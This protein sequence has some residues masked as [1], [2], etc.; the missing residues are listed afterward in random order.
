MTLSKFYNKLRID[1]LKT[2]A[3]DIPEHSI[4][5][6]DKSLKRLLGAT[7]YSYVKLAKRI[8]VANTTIYHY[9]NGMRKPD[10]KIM[11]DI[12]K[13]FD[14]KPS[15]FLEY[16][17]NEITEYLVKNPELADI[18]LDIASD[19]RE[20]VECWNKCREEYESRVRNNNIPY[21]TNSN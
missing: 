12:A 9:V 16:R 20:F 7:G 1:R 15:Y 4:E 11:E 17:I 14:I 8:N 5:P 21:P 13:V 19:P 6:M 10:N 2:W 18:F 3:Y